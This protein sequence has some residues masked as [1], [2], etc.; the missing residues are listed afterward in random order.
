[1][2]RKKRVLLAAAVAAAVAT[3][4]LAP[5]GLLK[6]PLTSAAI[7]ELVY[8]PL[9]PLSPDEITATADIVR[10]SVYGKEGMYFPD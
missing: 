3:I 7:E 8:H 4:S 1:M 6:V 5:A 10:K 9:N 2:E